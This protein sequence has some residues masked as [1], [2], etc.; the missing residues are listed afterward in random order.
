MRKMAVLIILVF[1][2][3]VFVGTVVLQSVVILQ[4]VA[5]VRDVSGDVAVKSRAHDTYEAVA[6]KAR[7]YAGDTVKTGTDGRVKLEWLDGTRIV[8]GPN[9]L[10]T[11]L[12]CHI[13]TSSH[14]EMSIFKL[15]AGSIWIRV[16]K[17]L[18]QKSKFEVKTPT[19]T[20]GVRGTVF[21]VHVAPDGETKVSVYEGQVAV[22]GKAGSDKIGANSVATL[23][24]KTTRVDSFDKQTQLSWKQH[25]EVAEP[26]LYIEQPDGGFEAKVGETVTIA[27]QS[28]KDAVVTVDG[29]AVELKIKQRFSTDV[30][31]RE[32]ESGDEFVV[33]VR[34]VDARGHEA[35]RNVT[36][37][38]I[39]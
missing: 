15:D 36:M 27:G 5:A 13:N 17:V 6:G 34:A 12:K 30:T 9:T 22:D 2:V 1:I 38:I 37:A 18:S 31:V 25:E 28:E 33:E 4:R 32:P 8:I 35:V 14:A 10:M 11:V 24:E 7:V 23:A 3:L 21:S 29:K 19:A 26:L 39:K 20:A 16:I